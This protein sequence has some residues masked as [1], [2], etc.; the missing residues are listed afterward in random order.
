MNLSKVVCQIQC[1]AAKLE[2]V[3]YIFSCGKAA[4]SSIEY[5]IALNTIGTLRQNLINCSDD[6]FDLTEQSASQYAI[7][8]QMQDISTTMLS[9]NNVL[10]SWNKGITAPESVF[11]KEI[12]TEIITQLLQLN[13]AIQSGISTLQQAPSENTSEV[14]TYTD[15]ELEDLRRQLMGLSEPD[16]NSSPQE[17]RS[18]TSELSTADGNIR[19]HDH[20]HLS[21]MKLV[22]KC[23][24]DQQQAERLVLYEFQK[25]PTA[26]RDYAI[27]A[28][29]TRWEYDNR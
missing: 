2:V 13:S 9:A 5:E 14:A 16:D 25:M 29:I 22:R 23:M 24:G 7:T 1:Q 3:E 8:R 27:Q 17:N 6:Y 12:F 21:F 20:E 15:P 19:D 26:S 4:V 28:A 18:H 11:I 10:I